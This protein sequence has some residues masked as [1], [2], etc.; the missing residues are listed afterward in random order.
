LFAGDRNDWFCLIADTV[1]PESRGFV[2]C[3][4]GMKH[5]K[6]TQKAANSSA[7]PQRLIK[8]F[9][10]RNEFVAADFA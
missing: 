1:N 4:M 7:T 6:D 3:N 9:L 8:S 10:A 5:L 2:E